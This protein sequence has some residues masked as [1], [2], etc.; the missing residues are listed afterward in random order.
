MF[1]KYSRNVHGKGGVNPPSRKIVKGG[2]EWGLII[3]ERLGLSP[4]RYFL[5]SEE[6]IERKEE[7]RRKSVFQ[8][9]KVGR[10]KCSLLINSSVINHIVI[11]KN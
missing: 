1:T 8:F 7:R 4:I 5:S 10:R 2:G 11:V 3:N 6:Y 9:I